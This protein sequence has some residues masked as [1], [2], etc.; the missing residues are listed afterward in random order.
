M[1]VGACFQCSMRQLR[2]LCYLSFPL[3]TRSDRGESLELS[4]IYPEYVHN[5]AHA[6][7]SVHM[8]GLLDS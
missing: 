8:H 5:L 4:Q 6:S 3:F 2:I 7:S 1:H